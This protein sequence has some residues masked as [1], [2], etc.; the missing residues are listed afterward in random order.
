MVASSNLSGS[1]L[2]R[3]KYFLVFG[4][5]GLMFFVD[6]LVSFFLFG[7][8]ASRL[9]IFSFASSGSSS[10][11]GAAGTFSSPTCAILLSTSNKSDLAVL[12][13]PTATRTIEINSFLHIKNKYLNSFFTKKAFFYRDLEKQIEASV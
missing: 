11:H 12:H 1:T 3:L 13:W 6:S 8:E 7:V 9:S 2:M 5:K 4:E 10:R